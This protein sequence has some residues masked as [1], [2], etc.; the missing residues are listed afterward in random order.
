[1]KISI[2]GKMNIRKN[3]KNYGSV[4]MMLM[5]DFQALHYLLVES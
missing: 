1:M 5:L 3:M 4:M 2:K